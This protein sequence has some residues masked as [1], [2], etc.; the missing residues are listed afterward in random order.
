MIRD[1]S[2][3]II[4]GIKKSTTNALV[5]DDSK[6]YNKYMRERKLLQRIE[7][8]EREVDEIKHLLKNRE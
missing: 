4:T 8:L 1:T 2:G 3:N 5:V 6:E 7:Q